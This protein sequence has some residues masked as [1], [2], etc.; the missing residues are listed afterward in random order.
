MDKFEYKVRS[1]EIR[2]LIAQGEY[3][4]AVDIADTIDWRRVKSVMMLCTISDLY[5]I[6]R[7]FE[8][9]KELLLLAY[10]RHPGGR[11]IVYSLCELSIK[12]GEFVQA[13]EYYKEFVQIAPKDTG[14]YILQYKLYVAQEVS[15]EERIEVLEELKKR[16]YRE[17]WAYELAYLYHRVGLATRCV[18]ECDE[19][20]LWFG[21]GK[22][23]TKAMELKM[24]HR[25]LTAEQHLKYEG[26]FKEENNSSN[27]VEGMSEMTS[28][29]Y[30]SDDVMNAP[31]VEISGDEIE[32]IQVKTMDVGEYNTI[33]LQKELADSLKE[34]WE[35]A[36]QNQLEDENIPVETE[37]YY[38]SDTSEIMAEENIIDQPVENEELPLEDSEEESENIEVEVAEDDSEEVVEES[39]S[40][41]EFSDEEEFQEEFHDEEDELSDT[42]KITQAIVAPL[43]RQTEDM[44]EIALQLEDETQID[45]TAA[46]VMAE[47][48]TEITEPSDASEISEEE[49]VELVESEEAPAESEEAPVQEVIKPEAMQPKIFDKFI[50][51]E[52]D[53]QMSFLVPETEKVEK[54]ITGQLNIDDILVEWERMKKENEEKQ[55]EEVRQRVLE[56]TGNILVDFDQVAKDGLL[57]KLESD[58]YSDEDYG[59][60][61]EAEEEAV[62]VEAVEELEEVEEVVD[63]P[64]ADDEAIEE[65]EEVV[66]EPVADDEA[67]EE[68]EEV[69]D[70]PV[71]DDEAIEETEEPEEIEDEPEEIVESVEI[72]ETEEPDDVEEFEELEELEEEPVQP[73]K[74]KIKEGFWATVEIEQ[75]EVEMIRNADSE[76]V[77]FEEVEAEEEEFSDEQVE[78]EVEEFDEASES[79]ESAG[80]ELTDDEK[81]LY[82][83]FIPN[84]KSKEQLVNAID[85][86]SLAPYTGN[87]I[88]TGEDGTDTLALAKNLMREVQMTDS[89]F[90]GKVA[91]ISGYAMNQREIE[92][93]IGKL[94]NGALIIQ[95]AG[96]MSA[97]AGE[98]LQK[99]LQQENK[100]I[101]VIM[102]GGKKSIGRLLEAV[103]SL[104]ETFNLCVNVEALDN[105]S[106][107]AFGKKYARQQEY[108]IDEMGLL[109]LHT[110]ISDRQTSNHAVTI[111]EV[112]EI[113]DKAITHANKKTIG[114]FFDVL[115]AKRY[116]D[117]DMIVLKEND[118]N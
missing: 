5:K 9:S 97:E 81:E 88:I 40:E 39:V 50:G 25:P 45:D 118:F 19:L 115:F 56:H 22:Y 68:A 99:A 49:P 84:I 23:V 12:M 114:H 37:V 20:I 30:A 10:D 106:L 34:L 2:N 116:D 29:E 60:T 74:K 41:E 6:N 94:D 65:A 13:I 61:V 53:G 67:I 63:E 103:P 17:K 79:N 31:T 16:D 57:E 110:C 83:S 7:R 85:S 51:M 70:E 109:A 11:T 32:D 80:R 104:K 108:S 46:I 55:A 91:K 18:E 58:D 101:V 15:L 86:I 28:D 62:E 36:P 59:V 72:E 93:V 47:M 38:S 43:F 112:Q 66:D 1:Q 78:A 90:S 24:L 107:V 64:E 52:Y 111:P 4:A 21:E 76:E 69:V 82:A 92:N 48:K 73:P 102:E 14:R 77:E 117:E 96:K 26:R 35:G 44:T 87:V 33:N 95:N 113:V 3:S 100:G 54:Q 75:D 8:E 105:D 27:L 42:Q 89:N 71:A 98:K